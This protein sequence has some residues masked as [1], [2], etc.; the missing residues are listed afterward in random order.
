MHISRC[1]L[2]RGLV[3][4]YH[5]ELVGAGGRRE[6]EVDTAPQ[7]SVATMPP[8]QNSIVIILLLIKNHENICRTL[9]AIEQE[10][11]VV[12]IA[13]TWK[14]SSDFSELKQPDRVG[15]FSPRFEL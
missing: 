5:Q 11:S 2:M 1:L 15:E 14:R 9:A 6:R 12:S 4:S 13:E 3:R 7:N 10:F 8:T